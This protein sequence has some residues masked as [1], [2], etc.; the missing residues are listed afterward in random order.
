MNPNFDMDALRTFVVGMELG[1]FARAATRLCRS[2]SAV[3]MQLKKLEQQ[4][5]QRLFRKNGRGLATTEAGDA[6]LAYARKI[7][8]LN[9]EAAA[10]IGTTAATASVSIGMAQDFADDMLPG[11]L[12]LFCPKWPC[13]HVEAMAGRNYSLADM[14]GKGSLDVA[15][16]FCRQDDNSPGELVASLP[17]RWLG[18]AAPTL[19]FSDGCIPLVM[20]DHPC[21]FRQ[22]AHEALD[23]AGMN[24]RMALTTPSL[25]GVWSALR[26]G[27]GITVRTGR[28]LPEDMRDVGRELDLPVLP[29]IEIRLLAG[30][31]LSPAALDL[32]HVTEQVLR[33]QLEKAGACS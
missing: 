2:Q 29:N 1:S 3:S 15:I 4:A 12:E 23:G 22:T 28:V 11:V 24:R 10:S 26:L 19:N 13:V 5:G 17:M 8:A 32:H 33:N 18:R 14:V 31:D 27:L 20:F 7:L 16:T 9:D 21:L 30:E 25:T 6:L